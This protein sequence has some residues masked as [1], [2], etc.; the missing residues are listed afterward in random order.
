MG[1]V[2]TLDGTTGEIF[3]GNTEVQTSKL[4]PEVDVFLTWLEAAVEK[5]QSGTVKDALPEEKLR[6]IQN[7]YNLK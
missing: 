4:N 7:I 3:Y 6:V 2:V 5:L 1:E